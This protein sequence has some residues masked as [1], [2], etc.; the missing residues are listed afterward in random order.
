MIGKWNGKHKK[1]EGFRSNLVGLKEVYDGLS[2]G[3]DRLSRD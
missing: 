1:N 3:E 2:V